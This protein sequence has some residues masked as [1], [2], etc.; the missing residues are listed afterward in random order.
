MS[1]IAG[2]IA[3]ETAHPALL[4]VAASLETLKAAEDWGL[5]GMP[6]SMAA[7]SAT[8]LLGWTGHGT[9]QYASR[10]GVTAV[11]DGRFYGRPALAE[12][13]SEA[14]HLIR[15]FR[16][17]GFPGALAGLNGDF[18]V[19]LFD[20]KNRKLWLA[21]DRFGVKPLYYARGRGYLAFASRPSALF[22]M[23]GIGKA[24][25]KEYVA[26]YAGCHYRY[27]DN[28]NAKSPY[29]DVAQLP[30]AHWLSSDGTS[31]ETG[32]YWSMTDAED[33]AGSD[34]EL[35]ERYRDLILDAVRIRISKAEKPAFTLSGGMDSS[36][37][38]ASS[39]RHLG[40][41]QIAFSTVY[42]DKTYD[43]SE[44]IASMLDGYVEKWNTIKIGHPDVFGLVER[45]V[46]VHD[47]PVCTAT[48][49][50]HFLL[51]EEVS[52]Q[53]YRT[54]FGGLGG[55]EL[56]AGEYEH[57]I[58]NFADLMRAGDEKA[59]RREVDMWVK[60]HDH[61][62]FKKDFSV[63][64]E[65]VRRSTDAAVPGRCLPDRVRLERYAA[66]LDE[67]FF[68]LKKWI[69]AMD[70]PFKS[71]LKNRTWQDI[72]RETI[73][74]CLRA[75][76]RQ[77][78]AFGI[79]N[80]VPFYDHRLAEFMFRVPNRQKIRDGRTKHLLREA[81]TGVLPEETRTR[82]K[83]VGW[84]APAHQWFSGKGL[85]R[86]NDLVHSAAFRGRG[87]YDLKEVDRL[88]R[89]HEDIV[90][91]GRNIDN[92]MMFFWQLVNLETWLLRLDAGA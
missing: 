58:P 61:P 87:I 50:S 24:V 64:E 91:H 17:M 83:K 74:P 44:D 25:R 85:D 27:F 72:Y 88:I 56:N 63:M 75:E 33:I 6:G 48:W 26:L 90:V 59:L 4:A 68:D 37:V 7:S 1:R 36:S 60:Y 11:V 45:M 15:R 65:M 38:L 43:E 81:M 5:H 78:T 49:L 13:D 29:A 82:T 10:D 9:V 52:R 19:A 77:T 89:E 67:G 80:C 3:A 70:H 55:D 57:F 42:D 18:S 39:V 46:A 32:V 69:P 20:S 2:A 30:A 16:E 35:A 14:A 8:A 92:H 23:P 22:G 21:R 84:N 53:G 62:V 40:R 79:E 34:A 41:K 51:C 76:D 66:T 47:E 28:D 71:Y 86:L 73:P 54:L 31:V 12:N